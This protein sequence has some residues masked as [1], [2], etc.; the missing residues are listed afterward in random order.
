MVE[1]VLFTKI[2]LAAVLGS[3]IGLERTVAGK[4]AGMRTFGLVSMGAALFVIIA[5]MVSAEYVSIANVDLIRVPAA[6]IS[7]IGFLGAG[8]IILRQ[9]VLRGL[10]T[11]AGLWV[12][13][14]V[15]MAVGFGMYYLATFV[16]LMT[17]LIFMG[18]WLIESR[19]KRVTHNEDASIV[20]D[21]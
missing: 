13:A 1:V 20:I 18:V 7:G 6:I 2:L 5:Q 14:G 9:D 15:G 10:T 21:E 4:H 17:L 19:V 8:M 16:V 11:A 12:T 3:L